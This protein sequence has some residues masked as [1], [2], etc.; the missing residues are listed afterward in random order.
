[1]TAL[2][3]DS[4][5]IFVDGDE[6]PG[7]IVYGL[8]EP[9][10]ERPV[11]V[12]SGAWISP[13]EPGSF[14]L[15]GDEWEVLTWE[16][17]IDVWPTGERW[18]RAVRMTLQAMVDRGARIAWLGAEGVPFCD[19]PE[20]FSP[21]CMSGGVLGW[22]TDSGEYSC[23]LDPDRPIARV[24]DDD[25]LLKLRFH[26]RGLADATS[27]TDNLHRVEPITNWD[28][29]MRPIGPWVRRA[30]AADL[31]PIREAA[32][33]ADALL[34]E[35]AGSRMHTVEELFR[36]YGREFSFPEY[37]GWN[38]AAFHECMTE[39]EDQPARA[40]LTLIMSADE[41]LSAEPGDLATYLRQLEEIGRHW[42]GAFALGP[43]W[44]GGE[45]PFHT[46]LVNGD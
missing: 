28:D 24:A 31:A 15:F 44:G 20:L 43:Q 30:A 19:P 38:C 5:T 37:F 39:L 22:M 33:T 45:V 41:V 2:A 14:R 8:F 29:V 3:R 11:D 4:L 17:P 36:E 35:L 7:F 12:P 32:T 26:A 16:I 18:Q 34:V 46:V 1:M 25:M 27:R 6:V 9:G 21:D 42:A 13:P 10:S 40:Y 23:E